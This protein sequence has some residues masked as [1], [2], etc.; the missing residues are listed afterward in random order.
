M[1][2]MGIVIGIID[3]VNDQ[4]PMVTPVGPCK[5]MELA[6]MLLEVVVKGVQSALLQISFVGYVAFPIGWDDVHIHFDFDQIRCS[7]SSGSSGCMATGKMGRIVD[8]LGVEC[9]HRFYCLGSCSYYVL[10]GTG[11]FPFL[12]VKIVL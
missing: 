9:L 3:K 1:D 4:L 6:H 2:Q 7:P 10:R 8:A 5:R 12:Q 11:C